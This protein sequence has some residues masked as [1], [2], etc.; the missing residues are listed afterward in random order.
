MD[1]LAFSWPRV[2]A[3]RI[4]MHMGL[5]TAIL[6]G[7]S[8]YLWITLAVYVWFITIGVS[9]GQ[10]RYFAHRTFSTSKFWEYVMLVTATLAGVSSVFGYIVLHRDHHKNTD[11]AL[12]P[13]SPW[14]MSSFRNWSLDLTDSNRWNLILAKDWL[15]NK[16]ILDSHKYFFGIVIVYCLLLALIDPML[17]VYAYLAPASLCVWVTASFNTWGH[18]KGLGWLGY[19]TYNTDDRSTN[20]FLV[21]LL[22]LGEGW[23]N[24]HHNS[25]RSW[26]QGEKW[27]E[28]D[29]NAQIIK[30]IRSKEPK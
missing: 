26:K 18:G 27:W 4:L 17:I 16:A 3:L 11:T 30:L 24:N 6:M 23:H 9:I 22:T 8:N 5:A 1:I 12:D 7:P 10:H 20:H 15:K 13:H 25:P 29:F 21:N 19:R 14:H 2:V 28:W